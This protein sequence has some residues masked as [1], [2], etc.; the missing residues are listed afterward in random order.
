MKKIFLVLFISLF[1][2]VPVKADECIN[3]LDNI[4]PSHTEY[5][6]SGY[7]AIT[8]TYS[9]ITLQSFSDKTWSIDN[10]TLS[11]Y[12]YIQSLGFSSGFLN[13]CYSSSCAT[14]GQS[15]SIYTD[16]YKVLSYQNNIN[17][18]DVSIRF[19]IPNSF[20][21][22]DTIT[23]L[24]NI[25]WVLNEGSSVCIPSPPQPSNNVLSSFITL[26]LDRISYLANGFTTNPYLL[27]MIAII[28]AF[29]V[30]ELFLHIF[31]LK[32]GYKK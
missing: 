3:L 4:T 28:F 8:I 7:H 22:S 18:S 5:T 30:L 10:N 2:L 9:Q 6:Y 26:Y 32:G 17:P 29:I 31:H 23:I 27:S 11:I 19:D 16:D 21:T 14:R 24:E 20:Y 25:P 1:F 13:I 12:E 15:I